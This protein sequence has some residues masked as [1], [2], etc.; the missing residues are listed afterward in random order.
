MGRGAPSQNLVGVPLGSARKR[1]LSLLALKKSAKRQDLNPTS[2]LKVQTRIRSPRTLEVADVGGND[3]GAV[4]GAVHVRGGGGLGRRRRAG[5]GAAV[6]VQGRAG[7]GGALGG[8]LERGVGELG[9]ED[10]VAGGWEGGVCSVGGLG[11]FV[12]L[13][14]PCS[15]RTERLSPPKAAFPF[16]PC[17]NTTQPA[18]RGTHHTAGRHN[19]TQSQHRRGINHREGSRVG[20]GHGDGGQLG[21]GVAVGSAVVARV[22]VGD[23]GVGAWGRFEGKFSGG[24]VA[25]G[26]FG[27]G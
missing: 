1:T 14:E 5:L 6:R 21:R 8:A 22:A 26:G 9:G 19:T 13:T 2:R 12:R 27:V 11:P 18:Q 24:R 17:G 4:D 20:G 3:H 7:D 15:C 10:D 23:G 25:L 16:P